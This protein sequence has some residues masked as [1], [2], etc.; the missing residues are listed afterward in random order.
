MTKV[1]VDASVIIASLLNEPEKGRLEEL[2]SG[3]QLVAP[4]S[5]PW[6]VGNALSASFKKKRFIDV[7]AAHAVIKEFADIPIQLVHVDLKD[8]I[9]ICFKRGIYAYDAYMILCARQTR[10]P[11]LT[12]D[13]RLAIVAEEEK[14]KIVEV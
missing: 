1:V 4:G 8:A 11:L 13:R 2:T 3:V 5:L 6:E 7:K 12:L 9:D 14:I 10:A